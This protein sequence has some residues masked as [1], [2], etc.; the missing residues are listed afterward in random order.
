MVVIFLLSRAMF[1]G[2]LDLKVIFWSSELPLYQAT[3]YLKDA[4]QTSEGDYIV[5]GVG[6]EP[7]PGGHDQKG[8]AFVLRRCLIMEMCNG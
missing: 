1:L 6:G 8:Q 2:H 3:H 5:V 7:G 4:I